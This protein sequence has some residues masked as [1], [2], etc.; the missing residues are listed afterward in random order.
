[1]PLVYGQVPNKQDSEG[2]CPAGGLKVRDYF[3]FY[4]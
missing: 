3:L 2:I 4:I 1:M